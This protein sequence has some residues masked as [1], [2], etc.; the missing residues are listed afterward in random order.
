MSGEPIAKSLRPIIC[1]YALVTHRDPMSQY[2]YV[3]I[4][5]DLRDAILSGRYA[6][7]LALS[8]EKRLAEQYGV[9]VGVIRRALAVLRVEGLIITVKGGATYIRDRRAVRL[10][11]SRY[12]RT[13]HPGPPGPFNA[14][15][16]DAG[17]VGSIKVEKVERRPADADIASRLDIAEGDMVIVR[18]RHMRLGDTNPETVQLSTSTIPLALV[19]GSPLAASAATRVYAAFLELGIVPTTMTDEVAARMSTAEEAETLG[20]TAGQPVLVADRVTRD[21]AGRPI[22]LVRLVATADRTVLVYDD[23]PLTPG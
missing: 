9:S 16:R 17:M 2:Q 12:G 23:L 18:V 22:E 5:A 6:P 19:E 20:I 4:A 3:P 13:L 7:G 1:A 8:S 14:A 21:A 11:L 15:A 10:A